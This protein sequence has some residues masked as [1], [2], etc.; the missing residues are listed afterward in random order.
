[1]SDGSTGGA[2]REQ[3][4]L[5]ALAV[6][7]ERRRVAHELHDTVIQQLVLARILIDRARLSGPCDHLDQVC[8]LLDDS[9]AELR[10]LV[11]ERTP[12]VLRQAGLCQA[13]E[14]ISEHM[15]QRWGLSF[16][17]RMSGEPALLCDAITDALFMGA[18]ELITNVG[19]HARAR[20]C[21][22]VVEIRDAH[23]DLTVSDDGIGVEPERMVT[24]LPGRNGGFGLFSLRSHVEQLG[25][26]LRLGRRDGGG[27]SVTLRLPHQGSA[28][29]GCRQTMSSP[30]TEVCESSVRSTP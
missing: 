1:M 6:Q 17:C 20:R 19:R 26:E 13:I 4:S 14:W 15:G 23:V 28:V 18:Q 9:L 27:A 24:R 11:A 30:T 10:L 8:S 16:S 2:N 12:A 25:G 22:V 3:G 5:A 21:D 29:R 7:R